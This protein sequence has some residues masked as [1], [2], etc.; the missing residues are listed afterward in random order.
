MSQSV[1][2]QN[3]L[4]NHLV[5][6]AAVGMSILALAGCTKSGSEGTSAPDRA[7]AT[8][9]SEA[10]TL[11]VDAQ[12]DAAYDFIV[13][14]DDTGLHGPVSIPKSIKDPKVR[15]VTLKAAELKVAADAVLAADTWPVEKD[16]LKSVDSLQE[17]DVKAKAVDGI[18]KATYANI[19]LG[20]TD[21]PTNDD[22]TAQESFLQK[23]LADEP[24]EYAKYKDKIDQ[25]TGVA[26]RAESELNTD[27][28]KW[29]DDNDTLTGAWSDANDASTSYWSDLNDAATSAEVNGIFNHS[30]KAKAESKKAETDYQKDLHHC[31]NLPSPAKDKCAAEEAV[32]DAEGGYNGLF[33]QWAPMVKDPAQ[34]L[35]VET[36][37]ADQAISDAQGDY[38]GLYDEW[39]KYVHDPAQKD[40][41]EAAAAD[42]AISDIKDGYDGL[43]SEW[44]GKV[45]NS[46]D[47]GR[48]DTAYEKAAESYY[49]QGY[50]GLG[51]EYASHITNPTLKA[52][53]KSHK[54]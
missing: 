28:T 30:P 13:G 33:A 20:L 23:E 53:A 48:I 49:D 27:S 41:M 47:R 3:F 8:T 7:P 4:H 17:P 6:A 50:D 2:Q 32:A 52:E 42:Q 19:L 44:S 24:A 46:T 34:E 18:A 35:R 9:S 40:R 25:F 12:Y 39:A 14:F 5:Q 29:S 37:A 10:P 22:I 15:Q 43:A 11:G 16:M 1:E 36:A 54:K 51:D 38:A 45:H 26:K 21:G 31:D